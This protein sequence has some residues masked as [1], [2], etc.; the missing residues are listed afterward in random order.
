MISAY[1]LSAKDNDSPSDPFCV[2]SLGDKVFNERE[3]Y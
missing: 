3:F 2:I 1:D